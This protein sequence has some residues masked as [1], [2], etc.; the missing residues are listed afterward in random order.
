MKSKDLVHLGVYRMKDGHFRKIISI[1]WL[2]NSTG[3]RVEATSPAGSDIEY[4]KCDEN[5]HDFGNQTPR[6]CSSTT[7]A[8]NAKECIGTGSKIDGKWKNER[9]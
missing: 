6:I 3:K 9:E 1:F 2:M 7:F 5:G 4:V 8:K